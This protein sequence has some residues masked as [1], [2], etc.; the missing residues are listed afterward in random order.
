[1]KEDGKLAAWLLLMSV[2]FLFVTLVVLPPI[3]TSLLDGVEVYPIT[4]PSDGRVRARPN[5]TW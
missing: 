5:G 3:V 4:G 2:V 1:M